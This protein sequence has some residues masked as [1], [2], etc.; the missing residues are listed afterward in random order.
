MINY[1]LTNDAIHHD[2]VRN[3]TNAAYLVKPEYGFNEGLFSGYDEEKRTYD[4]SSWEYV[5]GPDGFAERDMSLQDPRC[6]FQLMKKHFEP[7]TP[8]MVER[9]TGT[10]QDKFLQVAEWAASTAN[11]DARMTIMYALG[12]TQHSSGSQNIRSAAMIQLLCGNIG[13][14]GGGINALR[15]HSNVQGI[16][17]I[18]TLTASLPGYLAMPTDAEPTLDAISA[19]PSARPA[20]SPRRGRMPSPP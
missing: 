14:P 18:G 13:V 16:T 10:P 2:Y 15:G 11:G 19:W 5:I 17:D 1:L 4:R 6:V 9:I 12:W 20:R 3:Y 8:E 7:Y